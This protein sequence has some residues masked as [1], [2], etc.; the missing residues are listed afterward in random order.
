LNF[1]HKDFLI[2]TIHFIL[3]IITVNKIEK[4]IMI[5]LNLKLTQWIH[6]LFLHTTLLTCTYANDL[7][8]QTEHKER[9]VKIKEMTTTRETYI[10]E[11]QGVGMGGVPVKQTHQF[12][13]V[14]VVTTRVDGT[15]EEQ[16][17]T[18]TTPIELVNNTPKGIALTAIGTGYVT[19]TIEGNVIDKKV[20]VKKTILLSVTDNS[21]ELFLSSAEI[22]DDND[23]KQLKLAIGLRNTTDTP[24]KIPINTISIG[25]LITL[26][27][28]QPPTT[29][30]PAYR[31]LF[32]HV[33]PYGSKTNTVTYELPK[34][35]GT[36]TL[37]IPTTTPFRSYLTFPLLDYTKNDLTLSYPHL[38]ALSLPS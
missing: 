36:Y 35:N 28:E 7:N 31:E 26:S 32:I 17:T 19:D 34:I 23:S 25:N 27:S 6:V 11:D 4:D 12:N 38:M 30:K 9:I 21:A 5:Q 15:I 22:V 8:T 29:D 1:N 14:T 33:M 10:T 3:Y 13:K 18:G 24:I 2:Y 20:N 16:V 37:Q